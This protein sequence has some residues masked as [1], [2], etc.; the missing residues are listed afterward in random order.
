MERKDN[1]VIGN[2]GESKHEDLDPSCRVFDAW[3]YRSPVS[4]IGGL[5]I[6]GNTAY[7][8]ARTLTETAQDVFDTKYKEPIR[9][10]IECANPPKQGVQKLTLED[11]SVVYTQ[12]LAHIHELKL[13]ANRGKHIGDAEYIHTIMDTLGI[14]S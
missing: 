3:E 4:K 1:P 5:L 13:E 9:I 2:F 8:G 11:D 14:S 10:F 7:K 6:D 12:P